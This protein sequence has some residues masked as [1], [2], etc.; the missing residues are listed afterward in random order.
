[1]GP[2]SLN[3]VKKAPTNPVTAELLPILDEEGTEPEIK[4]VGDGD[5][6]EVI[7][8]IPYYFKGMRTGRIIACIAAD[9]VHDYLLAGPCRFLQTDSGVNQ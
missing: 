9:V 1:M 3:A 4:L 2:S 7:A 8:T 5:N 6:S